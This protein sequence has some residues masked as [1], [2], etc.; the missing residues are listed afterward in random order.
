M[1][2]VVGNLAHTSISPRPASSARIP[3]LVR[4]SAVW[5]TVLYVSRNARIELR[6]SPEEHAAWKGAAGR[7]ERTLSDWIR[8]RVNSSLRQNPPGMTHPPIEI[9]PRHWPVSEAV[10]QEDRETRLD[11]TVVVFD[12]AMTLGSLER[13]PVPGR[14]EE[15]ESPSASATLDVQPQDPPGGLSSESEPSCRMSAFHVKGRYCKV[16]GT[17]PE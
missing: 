3:H 2:R 4:P 10:P 5:C 16:C 14:P 15:G 17:V 13:P 1:P 7:E 8:L 12:E 11:Q 9:P 6:L